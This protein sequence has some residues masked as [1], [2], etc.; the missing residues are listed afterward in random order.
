MTPLYAIAG[1]DVP[2]LAEDLRAAR[3]GVVSILSCPH[4]KGTW[5]YMMC[6]CVKNARAALPPN[7][8]AD[9][10]P[11][12]DPEGA[13]DCDEC[14]PNSTPPVEAGLRPRERTCPKCGV[15]KAGLGGS[16][17]GPRIVAH[18]LHAHDMGRCLK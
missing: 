18:R 14:N 10:A 16:W 11:S 8:S 3:A 13:C 17:C 9:P 5:G 4:E 6:D 12:F 1:A 15:N 2:K 7:E